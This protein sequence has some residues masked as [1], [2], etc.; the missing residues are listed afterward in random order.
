MMKPSGWFQEPIAP[1]SPPSGRAPLGH[2][3]VVTHR[4]GHWASV[5]SESYD[6]VY[7]WPGI[8]MVTV[9]ANQR[10]GPSVPASRD[11]STEEAR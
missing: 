2:A 1:R 6:L 3:C 9:H 11:A 8:Q 5:A 4:L 7:S 10:M